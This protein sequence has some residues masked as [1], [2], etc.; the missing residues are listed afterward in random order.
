MKLWALLVAAFLPRR[1]APGLL[2][3]DVEV[4][5]RRPRTL[6]EDFIKD[7]RPYESALPAGVEPAAE[8][9]QH[10]PET[11]FERCPEL[12][13]FTEKIRAA[14]TSAE[15]LAHLAGSPGRRVLAVCDRRLTVLPR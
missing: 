5:R 9:L 7:A 3:D 4:D 12:E 2:G 15:M 10:F 8:V 11:S 1:P 14:S 13:A 6:V